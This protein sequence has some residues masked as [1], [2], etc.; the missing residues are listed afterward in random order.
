[1]VDVTVDLFPF[2]SGQ[3]SGHCGHFTA[4]MF[5]PLLF[6]KYIDKSPVRAAAAAARK[7]TWIHCS[8]G[9]SPTSL[10]GEQGHEKQGTFPA[11]ISVKILIQRRVVL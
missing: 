5:V 6:L 8:E 1:M 2:Q 11:L 10:V 4:T 9:D 3:V 7:T